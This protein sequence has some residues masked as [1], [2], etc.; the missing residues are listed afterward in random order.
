MRALRA[1]QVTP[2]VARKMH[3]TIDRR[4]TRH[5]GYAIIQ[6]KRKRVEE[7]I[8]W[9]KTIGGL[10]QTLHRGADRVGWVFTFATAAYNLVRMRN[11]LPIAT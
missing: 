8:G 11:L 3:S 7:I 5:P 10:R 6:I 2:H 9:M 4:T 1:H